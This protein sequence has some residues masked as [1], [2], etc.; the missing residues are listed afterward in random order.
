MPRGSHSCPPEGSRQ[1]PPWVLSPHARLLGPGEGERRGSSR[2]GCS[3]R[4]CC[5]A[6]RSARARGSPGAEREL[7]AAARRG[8]GGRGES[9]ARE[10]ELGGP[11]RPEGAALT[12]PFCSPGA[13]RESPRCQSHARRGPGWAED[14][15]GSAPFPCYR[16]ISIRGSFGCW[17][18]TKSFLISVLVHRPQS[19]V[20]TR[21][22]LPCRAR[23][24]ARPAPRRA[25]FG[26]RPR[27][28][29]ELLGLS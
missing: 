25:H 27:A 23:P 2:E 18:F 13:F 3:P 28:Y 20:P 17:N 7:P 4:P 21:V 22:C 8:K 10:S 14:P 24:G 11:R 1:D 5:S 12:R 19:L 9:A 29:P 6:R 26:L 16:I 15:L